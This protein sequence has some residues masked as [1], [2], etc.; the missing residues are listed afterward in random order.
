MISGSSQ[1]AEVLVAR[2][3]VD[4]VHVDCCAVAQHVDEAAVRG[5]GRHDEVALQVRLGLADGEGAAA[6]A[7][8]LVGP[9]TRSG[10]E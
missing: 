8:G 1:R 2:G 3:V 7:G 6:A 5:G 4:P 10:S 9:V